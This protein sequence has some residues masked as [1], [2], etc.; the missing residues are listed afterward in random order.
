VVVLIEAEAEL[1]TAGMLCWHNDD[2]DE[3]Q[4]HELQPGELA[5]RI[6]NESGQVILIG[7]QSE[8]LA[9]LRAAEDL[10]RNGE[11]NGRYRQRQFG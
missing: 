3:Y 10:L 1:M 2:P 4:C 11:G 6:Y 9:Q 8:L 7:S 5:L